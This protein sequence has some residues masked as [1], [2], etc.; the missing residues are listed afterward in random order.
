MA[1]QEDTVQTVA[2][3]FGLP[4]KFVSIEGNIG[5]GKSTL[6]ANLR[7][8]LKNDNRFVFLKEPVDEWEQIK[9]V[10]G[11]TMLQ[12]FYLDQEKY[13]FSFQMMAY[14]SR[15]ATFKQA[16]KENPRATIFITERSLDT[17]KNVFAKMLYESGKID[18]VNYQIYMKWFHTF[19]DDFPIQQVV[20]VKTDPEICHNR[21]MKRSRTGV[22]IIP[23]DYLIKCN[24]YHDC[25]M[26]TNSCE[27]IC[28][29]QLILDGNVDIFQNKEKLASW[30]VQ[31]QEFVGSGSL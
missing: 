24:T 9:D 23:L 15:L 13:S 30:M 31:F 22:D 4:P 17:D 25:M 19:A 12:K 2:S 28:Q 8:E 11:N 21:I 16:V 1:K 5:S 14:I 20:Y 27:C 26:D 10:D 3:G 18:S 29:N 6:L 7:E